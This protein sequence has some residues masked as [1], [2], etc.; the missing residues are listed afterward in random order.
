M[1]YWL[2]AICK[3]PAC[4]SLLC[5]TPPTGYLNTL[6]KLTFFNEEVSCTRCECSMWIQQRDVRMRAI[7]V[8]EPLAHAK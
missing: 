2:V 4:R 1:K 5:L 7:Q 8:A 3:N 6:G